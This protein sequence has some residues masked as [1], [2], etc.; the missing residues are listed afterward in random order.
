LLVATGGSP[1]AKLATG[2]PPVATRGEGRGRGS[3]DPCAGA[4]GKWTSAVEFV[5]VP[6]G[7]VRRRGGRH[8][9]GPAGRGR[10]PRGGAG[11]EVDLSDSTHPEHLPASLRPAL[12]ARGLVNYFEA[13]A[14]VQALEA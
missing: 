1:V 11:F 8:G 13:Q 3:G 12:P 6:P 5:P 7:E 9:D 14:V 2:E 10:P 4:W